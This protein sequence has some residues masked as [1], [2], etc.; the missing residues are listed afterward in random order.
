[1]AHEFFLMSFVINMIL[2]LFLKHSSK[3]LMFT[4]KKIEKK[5]KNLE[6]VV[7]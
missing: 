2:Y 1:M 6:N 3:I 4:I 5:M 7:K